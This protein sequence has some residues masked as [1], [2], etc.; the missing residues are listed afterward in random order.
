V[1]R[2]GL[3]PAIFVAS[4]RLAAA[5]PD[6][7][8]PSAADP[9]RPIDFVLHVDYDYTVDKAEITRERVGDP[10]ADPLGPPPKYKD[11]LFHQYTHTLTP[12]LEMGVFH[13]TWISAA[14]PIVIQQARELELDGIDRATSSTIEDGFLPMT[15]FD[16]GNPGNPLAGNF[17]FRGADRHGLD[18]VHLGLG[19]APMNQHRDDTK[20]TWKLGGE[21]RLS[22]GKIMRFDAMNP[23]AETGVSTGVHELRLWTTVDKKLGW[24]EPWFELWWQVPVSARS[25]SL[26]GNPGFGATNVEMGQQAGTSFGLEMYALDDAANGNKISL[27][28]GARVI[29][30]FE[31]RGYSEMWEVFALAGDARV[32]TNPLILDADPVTPG[33]QALSHPGITNIENYLE[34]RARVAVRA[35]LGPHVRF[36]AFGEA[37]WKT[38]HAITFAD[39]GVDLPTCSA[40]VTT[41]CETDDNDLVNPGTA[42]VNPLHKAI[43]DLVG[44]RYH[45]EHGFSLIIGVETLFMF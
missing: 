43:I 26:F 1:L 44:H 27:D 22:V 14:L 45:A 24:A 31:G 2:R 32:P 19:F 11:L 4:S 10:S 3:L 16:A 40:T 21:L 5:N 41:H 17:V 7:V 35:E 29:A 12:R 8:V 15:G 13:D 36:S 28:L 38:D 42:E 33:V 30:H 37:A 6:S 39:A 23:T 34:T 9:G 20:P 25:D 18:Q